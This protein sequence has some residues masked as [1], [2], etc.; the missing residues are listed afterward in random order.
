M[1]ALQIAFRYADTRIF[2][3]LV[4]ALRGGDSAHCEA[5]THR[6]VDVHHCVSASFLDK[7]VRPKVMPLPAAKWRVYEMPAEGARGLAWLEKHRGARYDWPG[8]LGFIVPWVKHKLS[9]WF[10]SEACADILGLQDPHR[11]DLVRLE[12][13]CVEH[14][15]RVQ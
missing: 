1:A 9:W 12:A 7:G 11:Y 4:C 10:C 15:R 3:R 14:G 5:S 8:L 6:V 13:Y 2:A